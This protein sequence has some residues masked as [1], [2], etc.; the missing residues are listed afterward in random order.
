MTV[1]D[2]ILGESMSSESVRI[3]NT[4]PNKPA[5]KHP[6][7]W[8]VRNFY[9]ISY[10]EMFHFQI[11]SNKIVGRILEDGKKTHGNIWLMVQKSGCC[12]S[13]GCYLLPLFTTGFLH[14]NGGCSE[15]DSEPS[16]VWVFL[17]FCHRAWILNSSS[18][19]RGFK[20]QQLG[21]TQNV[22]IYIYKA[23]SPGLNGD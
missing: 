18:R 6:S 14:P 20:I 11:S 22:D 17:R 12:T 19:L 4:E 1:F 21:R 8:F 2:P 15:W 7:E 16:T 3:L 9:G 23:W 5:L 13:R 10:H